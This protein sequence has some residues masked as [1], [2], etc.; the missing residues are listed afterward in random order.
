MEKLTQRNLTLTETP[1]SSVTIRVK[2][3]ANDIRK[4]NTSN[5]RAVLDLADIDWVGTHQVELNIE[6]LVPRKLN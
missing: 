5:L 4:L 1:V 6:G 3:L 2:G